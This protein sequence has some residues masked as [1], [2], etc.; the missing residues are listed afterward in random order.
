[1]AATVKVRIADLARG[2]AGVARDDSGR[3]IFVPFTAPGDLV[4]VEIVEEKKNYAQGRL[5][6]ILESSPVRVEPRCPVFARCGGCQWQHLPYE[7]QW[8][9][10]AAGA[11]HAL[12]R[13]QVEV[14]ASSGAWE[15]FPAER[16]W[17]YRNRVQARGFG[18]E[19]GFFEAGSNRRVAVDFCPIA[20]PEIN[21]RWALIRKQGASRPN[22]YKVEIEVLEEGQVREVWNAKHAA[23]GFR[24]IHDEQNEK[25]KAWVASAITPGRPLYDLFGGSGNLSRGLIG[26]ASVIHCVDFGAPTGKPPSAPAPADKA[27]PLASSYFYHRSDVSR[28]I[29]RQALPTPLMLSSAILDPPRE[30]LGSEFA[31][32]A[33]GLNRLGVVELVAVGCDPDSWARDLS[34][35][36]RWGWK[37]E[38]AA[39]F[40]LFPQTPHVESVALLRRPSVNR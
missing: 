29:S 18:E 37:V 20:R 17:E 16:I 5:V 13:T 11:K 15:E 23:L 6:S 31:S 7:L 26:K 32:I 4:E 24:Q 22:P 30:G 34:R 27:V 40:D 21:A 38:R 2:G 12:T 9:T 35:F 28:W 33:E 19:L 8:K 3:V 10:K 25:L 39:V 14:S 1:M 36:Q